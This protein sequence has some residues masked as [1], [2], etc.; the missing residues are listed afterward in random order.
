M[1][2]IF[3]NSPLLCSYNHKLKRLDPSACSITTVA[4]SGQAGF[5]DGRSS[6][7]QLS[8]PGGLA[9]GPNNRVFIADTNNF[10]IRVYDPDTANL[11]TLQLRNVPKPQISPDK[12]A[13]WTG[14]DIDGDSLPPGATLVKA[15]EPIAMS[16]DGKLNVTIALPV[17]YH[18]TQGANSRFE[19]SSVGGGGI[20]FTPVKGPLR[21][22]S[23]SGGS[24]AVTA[25]V[26][27]DASE[28]QACAVR[29]LCTV[30]FCQ[31]KSVCLFK[32]VVFE[33][34]LAKRGVDAASFAD[35]SFTLSAQSPQVNLPNL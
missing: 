29:V 23:T 32:E 17:G 13:A 2:F 4:G 10:L 12:A 11:S 34:E 20:K 35:L 14:G 7:A 21:E 16:S 27:F 31:D 1:S 28:A 25:Q 3:L 24:T 19:C 30:Y 15:Q 6:T 22:S 33:V 8:E 9:I 26:Q 5:S 18:L